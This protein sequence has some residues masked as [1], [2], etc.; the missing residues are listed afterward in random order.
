MKLI[1]GDMLELTYRRMNDDEELSQKSGQIVYLTMLKALMDAPRISDDVND[2]QYSES[3]IVRLER[4]MQMKR[5]TPMCKK[6]ALYI[7]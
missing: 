3:A 2:K 6:E 1:D 5:I 4:F 7:N